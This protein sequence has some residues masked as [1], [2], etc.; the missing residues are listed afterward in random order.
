MKV[1]FYIVLQNHTGDKKI[2]HMEADLPFAPYN[3]LKL[4]L[5][6]IPEHTVEIED[7]EYD[8]PGET[9]SVY[10]AETHYKKEHEYLYEKV[11][12]WGWSISKEK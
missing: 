10:L 11:E 3:G 6:G 4:E 5:K 8:V 2:A 12:E 7:L 1:N 9:W